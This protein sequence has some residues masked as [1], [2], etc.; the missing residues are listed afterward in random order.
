MIVFHT[1]LTYGWTQQVSGGGRSS[2]TETDSRENRTNLGRGMVQGG[3]ADRLAEAALA[4]SFE[5]LPRR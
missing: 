2:H 5:V 4:S 3:L 1:F